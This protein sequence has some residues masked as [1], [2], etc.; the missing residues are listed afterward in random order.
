MQY[1]L[2]CKLKR[3]T[4]GFGGDPKIYAPL[5]GH[6]ADD[7]AFEWDEAIP[8]IGE[9]NYVYSK[10]NEG[11]K[12]PERYT[13]TCTIVENGDDVDEIIYGH[14]HQMPVEIG[15]TYEVGETAARAGNKGMTFYNGRRV[16]LEEKLS[17]SHLGTHLH[18]QRRPLVKVTKTTKGKKYIETAKGKLKLN[19]FFYEIKDYDNGFNGCAPLEYNGKLAKVVPLEKQVSLL[20]KLLDLLIKQ[21]LQKKTA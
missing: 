21:G 3:K 9:K 5:L 16:S 18:L 15:R 1:Y 19:G 17:G 11:S 6:P 12:D 20:Q 13:G 10:L 8:F 4:Q 2:P 14:P 7:W